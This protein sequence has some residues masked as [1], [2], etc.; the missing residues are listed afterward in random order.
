MANIKTLTCALPV[1]R[2]MVDAIYVMMEMWSVQRPFQNN[3]SPILDSGE[4]AI[5]IICGEISP[6]L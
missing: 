2:T 5:W 3:V 4:V 1:M 6:N